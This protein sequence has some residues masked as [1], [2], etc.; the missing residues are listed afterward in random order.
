MADRKLDW[1]MPV[2]RAGYAGRGFTYVAIAA[3]SLYTIWQGG[4]AKGTSEALQTIETS[5]FGTFLLVLIGVGLICYTLWRV[6]DGALDLEDEGTDAKGLIARGGMIVTGLI[7]GALGL[8]ALGIAFGSSSGGGDGSQIAEMT[9]TVMSAPFGIWLVGLAGLATV[10]AGIYYLHKAY[11]Q[12]YREKLRGNHFTTHWNGALRAGVAAQGVTVTI[13]GAFLFYAA[14]TA[15]PDQAGGLE[16]AFGWLSQQV[17]GQVLVTALCVGL[18]AFAGFLFVNAVYRIV[19][20]LSDPDVRNL[21]Q[22]LS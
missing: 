10:G 17:Y 9:G 7:H 13:I 3:L 1:A 2:M 5:P 22:A 19:P 21:A 4:A 20:R 6:L 16:K 15:N 11:T 8:A 14:L 18:L 12:S